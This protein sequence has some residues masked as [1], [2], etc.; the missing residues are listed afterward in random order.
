[1]LQ[2]LKSRQPP[3]TNFLLQYGLSRAASR[4]GDY[5]LR[6][7]SRQEPPP[8]TKF[9]ERSQ[10]QS[11]RPPLL[12]IKVSKTR[13]ESSLSLWKTQNPRYNRPPSSF[14]TLSN[15]SSSFPPPPRRSRSPFNHFIC[16]HTKT[17][18][19]RIFRTCSGP[20]KRRWGWKT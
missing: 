13:V 14:L 10:L 3:R 6:D 16:T 7:K 1:M 15:Y 8:R 11:R 20:K 2:D 4:L 18:K 19:F 5:S 9:Y 17:R 12:R